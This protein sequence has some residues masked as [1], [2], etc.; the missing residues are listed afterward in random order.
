M[1]SEECGVRIPQN[2]GGTVARWRGGTVVRWR[3][4]CYS[5]NDLA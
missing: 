3:E 2:L 1:W 5:A 4:K